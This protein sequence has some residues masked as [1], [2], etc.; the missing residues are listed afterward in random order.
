MYV[1]PSIWPDLALGV[2]I[3]PMF[4]RVWKILDKA[5]YH[6][7][8]WVMGCRLRFSHSMDGRNVVLLLLKMN[9]YSQIVNAPFVVQSV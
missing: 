2:G 5:D 3:N 8:C 6:A 9:S 4:Y 1:P 7:R